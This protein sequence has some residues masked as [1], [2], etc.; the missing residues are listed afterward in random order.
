[1]R[2][3]DDGILFSATDLC[4][5]L[6]CE[7]LTALDKINLLTPL[8]QTPDGEEAQ[9]FQ[10]KG[11][12]HEQ[13]YLQ[14]LKDSGVDVTD[15]SAVGGTLQDKAVA[16]FEAMKS[17]T[18]IIYQ[19]TLMQGNFC[20]YPDFL[21]KVRTPS[22]LGP[23]S[24]EVMD[25]KLAR[26][27]KTYFIIQLCFYSDLLTTLQGF[28]PNMMHVVLGDRTELNFRFDQFGQYYQTLKERF[29]EGISRDA[30]TYPETTEHCSLCRWRGLCE[31]KWLQDDHLNQVANITK[32]QTKKLRSAGIHTLAQLAEHD[33]CVKI[34]KL[35]ADTLLKLRHQAALQ[36]KKRN[37]GANEL[38]L[39][40]LDPDGL[41]GFHRLPKPD[42][43]DLFFDMEGDPLEPEGLE[44]L[45]GV[46]YRDDD[47]PKFEKFW[48]HN[49][50][51]ERKAFEAFMDFVAPRLKKYPL[52]H[53]Y[54]YASYEESALKRLMCSHGIKEAQ[55][56]DLL[57]S[58]KLVD[59]YKVVRE[60]IR[61]SEPRYSIKNLET[62][63]ADK[64]EGD[65][66]NAMSSIVFYEKWLQ[67]KDKKFLDDIEAYN[68]E[69]CRSTYL[70]REWLLTFRPPDLPWMNQSASGP[71][72]KTRSKSSRQID[73]ETKLESYRLALLEDHRIDPDERP[74]R[75]LVFYLLDFHRRCEKP[76]WWAVFSRM[77]MTDEDLID[78]PECIGGMALARGRTKIDLHAG[79]AVYQY[80]EQEFKLGEGDK[81]V[82]TGDF[83]E[84]FK[85]VRIDENERLVQVASESGAALPE[86][87]SVSTGG[88]IRSGSLTKAVFRFADS[89]I[90]GDRRYAAL[91]AILKRSIPNIN[92]HSAGQ[93]IVNPEN[94]H[95]NEIIEAVADLR[96]SYLFIQGPPGTGKTYTG[97]HIIAE[98][99][100][101][102]YRV[103]VSSNS[104]KAINNL[105]KHV[106]LR[107]EEIGLQF[108]GLKKSTDNKGTWFK[109]K[110]IEDVTSNRDIY[111]SRANLVAG[112]AWLFAGMDQDLDFLF[113]DEAGQV[114][115]ANLIAMGVSARN[116]VLLGDQMQLGQPIQGVHPGRSGESTLEYLLDGD[117]TIKPD[118]GVFLDTTWR[119]CP[120]VC[121]FISDAVYDSRLRPE[122]LNERQ[123]LI[124]NS[125]A[126][127]S[128]KPSGVSFVPIEHD[129][130]S[131]KSQEEADLIKEI[132]ASLVQQ[133]YRDRDGNEQ[134]MTL[135]N[136]M[137][138][139][140]YNM[141]VNL[142]KRVLPKGARVGTV[143][144]FQGQ[145]SE[146][147]IVS[148]T[149]SS[150]EYL[151]RRIEFLYSKN[152]LNVAISRARA[153][154]ILV[155]NPLLLSIRCSAIDQ[156]QLVNTLCWARNYSDSSLSDG[157]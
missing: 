93:P 5:F 14:K 3:I 58:H 141:Q 64:R 30:D 6:E 15:L 25:T 155:V 55:V 125:Q 67:T 16:T 140:P 108:H 128:L 124:L 11:F 114:S 61:V 118:R 72:K 28:R 69:D 80:P 122:P 134:S 99:L 157:K 43:G 19:G 138:V 32:I 143:D 153:L 78:D 36:L 127:E 102:G 101:R 76:A 54:H 34:Q 62:F 151:P 139:A 18:D 96:N 148:M 56:D 104:H 1:M 29:L 79:G 115:L 87:L 41:R 90:R 121:R 84:E 12:E 33:D 26:S 17:G 137:V 86:K 50:D 135:G 65:V 100:R 154:S 82:H 59:L 21:R 105:L 112:T 49:R 42:P 8:P 120:D 110:F 38:E 75:E 57:R 106:E 117:A 123:R 109:G 23:F 10:N 39:L 89:I 7:H 27:P 136:I 129:G 20:G 126:Q 51:E 9:L 68:H 147:V 81:C 142:L 24:Y 149:T 60:S 111:D 35:A 103:G 48:A 156:V 66:K 130:C 74:L 132:M 146:V 44:Y 88:P 97:S 91:E 133:S 85:I 144:K 113:V 52:A 83:K 45:F 22:G 2:K 46:Y 119:M 47:K 77:E 152:R 116:I 131:Q 63:Y 70:L 4:N 31:E 94:P 37:S 95:L 145:E 107:A 53:I 150:G 98:L 13:S 92:D 73:L 71:G 40:P